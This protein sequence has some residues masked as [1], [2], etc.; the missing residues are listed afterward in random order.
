M[1]GGQCLQ[2]FE[3]SQAKNLLT[4]LFP[5]PA[6]ITYANRTKMLLPSILKDIGQDLIFIDKEEQLASISH[7]NGS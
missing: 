2:T 1:L 3:T 5:S 6:Y 4:S 7:S